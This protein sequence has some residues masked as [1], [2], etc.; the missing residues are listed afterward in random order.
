MN[1]E[2]F[3]LDEVLEKARKGERVE[4]ILVRK[5]CDKAKE[6]LAKETNVTKA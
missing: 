4:E 3:N 5:L 2:A 6:I 1:S